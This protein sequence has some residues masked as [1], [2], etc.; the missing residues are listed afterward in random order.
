MNVEQADDESREASEP[1]GVGHPVAETDNP[2]SERVRR[3]GTPG[4]QTVEVRVAVIAASAALVGA[5]T[6]S[7]VTGYFTVSTVE[8]QIQ[9]AASQELREKRQDLYVQLIQDE[10]SLIH[11]E[12]AFW[13]LFD[14]EPG[15]PY[16]SESQIRELKEQMEEASRKYDLTASTT[17][18]LGAGHTSRHI[19]T[20]NAA[21]DGFL[22]IAEEALKLASASPTVAQADEMYSYLNSP[23][24]E[25]YRAHSGL[26]DLLR[27][28]IT[29][30]GQ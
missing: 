27:R 5:V 19:E 17:A 28:D 22:R 12:N 9:A 16:P 26:L 13:N 14:L 20:L 25:V 1:E 7:L 4:V 30:G 18:L 24:E 29:P 15:S 10:Q 3:S 6:G 21:H 11:S 2:A 8:R 23:V